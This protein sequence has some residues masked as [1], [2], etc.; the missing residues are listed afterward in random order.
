MQFLRPG[1]YSV[2]YWIV[3]FALSVLAT[4]AIA[5]ESA[6][7]K[8]LYASCAACH[9]QQA[10]GNS[11]LNSPALAGQDAGYLARQLQNFKAGRR[12]SSAADV[13]GSQ[14]RAM[15]AV[16]ADEQAI[17]SV[18]AYLGSLPAAS[19]TA[20]AAG[21]LRNGRTRYQGNCGACH[22]AS[23]EGNAALFAPRLTGIDSAYL[24]RQVRNFQQGLRGTSPDDRYGRQMKLMAGTLPTETDLDDVL[25][26][27]QSLGTAQ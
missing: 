8:Q 27:I 22:G 9:G 7:G 1:E 21:D 19:V 24:K 5:A 13:P 25:A 11:A 3:C 12:G 6:V 15:A 4:P 2:H 17:A 20:A 16:L 18:A 10:E 26:Y 23:A 14:M